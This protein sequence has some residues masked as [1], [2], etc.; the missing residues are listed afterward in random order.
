MKVVHVVYDAHKS[1]NVI[2]IDDALRKQ[3]VDSSI[4]VMEESEITDNITVA[5]KSFID[6]L[7][8]RL[9]LHREAYVMKHKY[10]KLPGMVFSPQFGGIDIA[11]EELVR[12]ADVIQLHWICGNYLNVRSISKLI[13]LEKPIVW[14][15][16]DKWP[17]TGGCHHGC[18]NY[19]DKCGCCPVLQSN[20]SHD[21]SYRLLNK[22]IKCWK[23]K[24]IVTVG[25][26]RYMQNSARQSAVF[27]SGKNVRIPNPVDTDIFRSYNNEKKQ[28]DKYKV[29]FGAIDITSPYKGFKYLEACLKLLKDRNPDIASSIKLIIFGSGEIN[30]KII[31]QYDYDYMGFIRDRVDLAK[32]YSMADLFIMPSIYE[33][34]GNACAEALSCETP[35]LA[36]NTGGIP[37]MVEH[38]KN[39]YLAERENAEDLLDGFLWI[40]RNNDN[41]KLGIYGREKMIKECSIEV[42]GKKYKELYE[43]VISCN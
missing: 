27:G 32:I 5:R 3:G 28:N 24:G 6:K 41:N 10:H 17:L 39:G 12:E 7:L 16:L 23:D 34:F 2:K 26:S 31:K 40:F 18:D 22:K 9:A 4:L 30:S 29:C 13:T 38:K 42:V 35:V 25:T 37:D 21:I 19:K 36:F 20:D 11:K 14:K 8:I 15:M 43:N 1:S 33:A